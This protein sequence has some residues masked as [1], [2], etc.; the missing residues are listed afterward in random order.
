M[1]AIL[2]VFGP[3]RN[4]HDD[5]RALVTVAAGWRRRSPGAIGDDATLGLVVPDGD[6]ASGS[7]VAGDTEMAVAADASF[8]RIGDL[9]ARVRALL[10]PHPTPAH[11]V[12]AAYRV[13]GD[14]CVEHLEG[15]YA[16]VVWIARERRVYC[17]RDHAGRRALHVAE[18]GGTLVV[19]SDLATIASLPSFDARPHA[20]T[21]GAD[22]A[23]LFFAVDDETSMAGVRTLPGGW[24]AG[25]RPADRI[26]MQRFWEPRTGWG[27]ELGF[28][29][30]AMHLRD[31]LGDAVA[32]RMNDAPASVWM[33]GGRDS[34]AVFAA[35]MDAIGRGRAPGASLVPVSRSHP[36]GDSGREDETITAVAERWDARP[37][38]VHAVGVPMIEREGAGVPWRT[39]S[40][41]QPYENLTRALARASRAAGTSVAFDGFGGDFLFQVSRNYLADEVRR[42]AVRSALADWHAIDRGREGI[43]GFVRAGVVPLLPPGLTGAVGALMRRPLAQAIGDRDVP[44]WIEPRFVAAHGLLERARASMGEAGRAA[45]IVERETRFYLTHPFFGRVNAA[46]ARCAREEGVELRSPLMDPRVIAFAL[47]RPREERNRA[48]DQKRLLRAAMRGLLPEEVL[49]PRPTKTGTLAT[50]FRAHMVKDGL[51]RLRTI[52]RAPRLA[53]WGIVHRGRLRRAVEEFAAAKWSYPH[54]EAL[55]CTL[56]AELWLRAHEPAPEVTSSSA[57]ATSSTLEYPRGRADRTLAGRAAR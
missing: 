56:M 9:P 18:R 53:E 3:A 48:G 50:Y 46:M 28:D 44:A 35:G 21:V 43:R 12:L 33:S 20:A 23:G 41:A 55:Y 30:A 15:D 17:A 14:R 22:A 49:A 11:V 1:T 24:S 45:T 5:A 29:D 54:V 31:L 38:W 27:A 7:T 16:F 26:A 6:A 19:A 8:Y 42:G 32:A 52:A 34:T 2:G 25:W 40:F 47:S 13:F 51:P 10:P 39:D 57:P 4:L 37:R 36:P